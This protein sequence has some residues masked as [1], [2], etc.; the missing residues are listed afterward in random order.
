MFANIMSYFIVHYK[1][2]PNWRI[3]FRPEL[4]GNSGATEGYSTTASEGSDHQNREME[5]SSF[6]IIIYTSY[7]TLYKRHL[8]ITIKPL[9]CSLGC[10]KN[11]KDGTVS[12]N[13]DRWTKDTTLDSKTESK[14]RNATI[15]L[16]PD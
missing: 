13:I 14:G 7:F 8:T 3:I 2:R 12:T 16:F 6:K 5:A 11:K 4:L 10:D 15:N 9:L 1:Y